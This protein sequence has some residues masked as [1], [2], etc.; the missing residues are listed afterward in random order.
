MFPM[1]QEIPFSKTSFQYQQGYTIFCDPASW[2]DLTLFT[3]IFYT[4]K[5]PTTS[6]DTSLRDPSPK[7]RPLAME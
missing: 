3:P 6:G 2:M 1:H 4:S 5:P 7:R